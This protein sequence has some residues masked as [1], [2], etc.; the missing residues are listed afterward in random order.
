[1]P[2]TDKP[3]VPEADDLEK[4]ADRAAELEIQIINDA[5]TAGQKA[6]DAEKDQGAKAAAEAQHRGFV[7]SGDESIAAIRR[8][9]VKTKEELRKALETVGHDEED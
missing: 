1:M 7:A 8:K 9:L 5:K 3:M 2:N 4:Q 6:I